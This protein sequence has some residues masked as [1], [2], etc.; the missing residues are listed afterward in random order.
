MNNNFWYTIK[1]PCALINS[2]NH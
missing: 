1:T 2:S